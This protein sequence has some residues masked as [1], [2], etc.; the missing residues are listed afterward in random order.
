[1]SEQPLDRYAVIGNP[2]GHSKSPTIHAAF[3]E[4]TVQAM[5][6]EALLAPLDGFKDVVSSFFQNGGKG[7]NITVPFKLEAW[8]MAERRTE[9]AELAGAV[10]TLWRSDE[11]CLWGDTTDGVGMVTDITSNHGITITGKR[12]LI[13]GAGGAVRGVLQPLLEQNP[14]RV[15]IANRTLSKAETLADLFRSFGTIEAS[16]FET[17]LGEFDLVIN[18]TSAS[19]QGDLPPIPEG[20]ISRDSRV[21]DMMYSA[22]KTA[23]MQWAESQGVALAVDGLGMLVEQ[24]AESFAIWRGVRPETGPVI[25]QVRAA[26]VA[27]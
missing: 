1:M 5:T 27:A 4:Q 18:G 20:V 8:Q 15:V 24:A 3:A 7:L 23:F 6:Y 12:V 22:E 2:V 25:R 14:D 11:G 17:L 10:N 19:L 26:M 9:R 21:Y 16:S 13:L